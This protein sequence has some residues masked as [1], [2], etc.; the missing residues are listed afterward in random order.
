MFSASSRARRNKM[1]TAVQFFLMLAAAAT[2]GHAATN[3]FTRQL[4]T[5]PAGVSASC[6]VDLDRK[7]RA[8]LLAADSV[9]KKILIYRQR[10]SGFTNVPD[11]AIPLPPQTGWIALCDVDAHPG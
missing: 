6:F 2:V 4:I 5:F 11:Q 8:D 1:R 7:G 10:V 3:E 9:E